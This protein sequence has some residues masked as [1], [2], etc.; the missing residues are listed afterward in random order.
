M[1]CPE[2][3]F[4]TRTGTAG[5]FLNGTECIEYHCGW[6]DEEKNCCS[7]KVIA[8]ELTRASL[9]LHNISSKIPLQG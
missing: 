5:V 2:R 7:I 6:W 1:I 4:S 3:E 8:K 9:A